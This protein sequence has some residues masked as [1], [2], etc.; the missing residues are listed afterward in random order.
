MLP[1]LFLMLALLASP[2]PPAGV[3]L[4]AVVGLPAVVPD[5]G[6]PPA[7]EGVV[8]HWY[9]DKLAAVN[10]R[11]TGLIVD[12]NKKVAYLI[13][14]GERYY[15]EMDLPLDFTAQQAR[16]RMLPETLERL[17]GKV[18]TPAVPAGENK[19]TIT[20]TKEKARIGRWNCTRYD[21]ALEYPN[22][23]IT[24]GKVWATTEAPK[25]LVEETF[26]A[27]PTILQAQLRL[28]KSTLRGLLRIKGLIVAV[29]WNRGV[30]GAIQVTD[31][32]EAAPPPGTFSPP[33]GYARRP[34]LPA[35]FQWR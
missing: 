22:N 31:I 15:V 35:G 14:H 25:H 30:P 5:G 17:E 6:A 20:S 12:L 8:E 29:E 24:V 9:W 18:A 11:Q 2:D 23:R 16:G 32:T 13:D 26:P 4:T 7:G 33:P 21:V 27:R 28:A 10:T 3:H 34:L 19:I 1:T